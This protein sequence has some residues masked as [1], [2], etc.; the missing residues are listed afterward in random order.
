LVSE[1]GPDIE[2]QILWNLL[3][4]KSIF[5]SN[6]ETLGGL[7]DSLRIGAGRQKDQPNEEKLRTLH[8]SPHPLGKGEGV[9]FM[10]DHAY[11]MKP[12]LKSQNTGFP[13]HPKVDKIVTITIKPFV[14]QNGIR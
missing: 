11:T 9:E 5:C 13:G 1:P 12:S 7:L 14:S 6:E 10:I 2:L 4:D 3:S 8:P